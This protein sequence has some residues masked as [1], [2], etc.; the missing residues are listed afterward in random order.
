MKGLKI[1]KKK[2]SLWTVAS[3]LGKSSSLHL[4]ISYLSSQPHNLLNQL[5]AKKLS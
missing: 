1:R 3:A 2:F 4:R 5:L